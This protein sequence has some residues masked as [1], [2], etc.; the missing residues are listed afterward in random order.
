MKSFFGGIV[1]IYIMELSHMSFS[2]DWSH[3]M[4]PESHDYSSRDYPVAGYVH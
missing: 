2:P 1:R 4:L 3:A